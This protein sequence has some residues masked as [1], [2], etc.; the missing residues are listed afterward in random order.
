M[1]NFYTKFFASK[2]LTICLLL[3]PMM[4]NAINYGGP[5]D[6]DSLA[7]WGHCKAVVEI[8]T[9]CVT[10]DI[11]IAAFV[12]WTFTGVHQPV[13]GT[14][15]TGQVA[16]KITVVPPGTWSWD[17]NGTT[18]EEYHWGNEGS[19][20]VAFFAGPIELTPPP[21]ICPN[22]GPLEITT[23]I[24]GYSNF[25]SIVWSP[26]NPAGDTEPYPITQP[27]TYGLTV[28]DAL[29]CTSS[30]QVTI[31][32][33]PVFTPTIIGP[34]RL[35]PEGDTGT[36]SIVNP[37]LYNFFEWGTGETTTPITIMDPGIYQVTATD[38]YGCTGVGSINVQSGN[39][40]P[41]SIAVSSSLLCPG[42]LDTLRVVGGFANYSWSNN[43]MGITNI[44]NQAGTYTVTVTNFYGCTGTAS[45]TVTPLFPPVI[46]VAG[47]PL[48]L[49]DTAIL[50]TTGGSF[51]QY[52]WS[53]GQT[54][55]SIST[56][57]PGTYSVTVS[58]AG[59]CATS[60]S[61]VLD[62]APAPTTI[63][64]SAAN[65][66]CTVLQTTLNG[67]NSSTGPTFPFTWKT[68]DG[69]FVSGDSTLNPVI[70]APGTYILSIVNTA[71]G[72]I[73][74]DTIVVMQN[75]TPPPADAGPSTMLNCAILNAVIG[76][77]PAPNDPSLLPS[78]SSMDGN[79]SSGQDTWAPGIDQP[80]TYIVLVTNA[81]NGCTSSASVVVGQDIAA[82]TA[83]IA[84][85]N[86]ITCMQGTVPLDGSGSSSGSNINY[87]WTTVNGL[88]AGPVDAAI[89]GASSIG[90]YDLLVTNTLNGC[91]TSASITVSA[92]VNIPTVGALPPGTLNC[93][94]LSTVI[95]ASGSS[96][97]PTF[98]YNWST[99]NGN[100]VS[101]GNTLMPSVNAPGAYT[102]NLLNTANNCAATLS[103]IVNQDITPPIA[104]A[105]LDAVL[106]CTAPTTIL[107]GSASSVGSNFTYNW[108]TA[109][110]NIVSGINTVFP[111]VDMDGT[112]TLQV[113]D[114]LNGCTAFASVVIMNDAN[115]PAALIAAPTTLTC[116]TLQTV[117]DATASTQT[118]N[119]SYAWSGNILSGQGTL[120]PIVD[121]P[122][123]YTLSI[124]NNTNGCTD[125]E[126][127]TV[128]QDILSP[129][130]QAGQDG[131]INCFNPSGTIGSLSNPSG[132]G[133]LLQWSTIGGNFISATNGP[134][135]LI[136][137]AGDYQLLITHTQNGCTSTDNVSVTADFN[138]PA[139]NAG[140]AAE[141]TCVQTSLSL[142]GSGGA[143]A[144]FNYLWTAA[145]G[146]NITSG[147]NSLSPVVDAPGTY[148]LLIT[149][150]INGCS[151]VSQ[152]SITENANG[153]MAS[154]G[155]PQTLTCIL[156]NTNLSAAG[157]STGAGFSYAW[158]AG[159]GGNI[160]A[161]ANTFTPS[162][163]APGTYTVTVTNTGNF[164][165]QTSSVT[166]LLN[167]QTPVVNAG[168][169]NT[170]TCVI[171]SLDLQA[172]I[173]SSSSQNIGYQWA[174]PTGQIISGG[175]TA[176]PIIGAPGNYLVTVTDVLNGC[177]GTDQLQI[178][179]DVTLPTAVIANPLMLTC[180]VEQVTLNAAASSQG[181]NFDYDWTTPAGNFVS[182]QNPQ[183]PIV[184]EQGLYNL[185]ITNTIN[186]CTQSASVTVPEDL[187]LPDAEAGE[188]V[189]LD[190]DTQTNSL[191]GT[192]SS[193]GPE[194]NY[195]WSTMNGQIISGINTLTPG[196]GAPGN[197]V[198][199]VLNMQNGCV[200]VDNVTVTQDVQA[201]LLA[202]A[203]PQTLTCTITSAILK[204]S[205]TALGNAPNIVW[206][207]SNGN[208][209]AGGTSLAPT[210]D[211]PG[212]YTLTVLNP[213]N[214]CS[215]TLPVIVTENIQTPPLQVQPAPLLT[216]SVLQFPLES[217]VPAQASMIW[218]TSNGNIVS[219]ANTSN[220]TVDEPG[221]YQLI[222][223]SPINGCTNSAQ[224][225]VQQELNI[226]TGL[227]FNLLP[228]LCNGTPGTLTV[229]QVN[230]G[231]GPFA[232]SVDGGQTF[233]ASEQFGQLTPG[234]Y[235]LV[236]QDAN[237][238]E[239]TESIDVPSPPI[240]LVTSPPVFEIALGENQE[241]LAIVPPPFPLG[242]VD[243]VI[244][245]PMNGLTFEGNTTLQLLHPMAQPFSTTQY[246]VTIVTK[247]GCKSS[248]RTIVK[249]D[250][251]A[252][253]YVP[254]VFRPD[255][256]DGN[257]G[258]FL[259][260]A[261]DE[262]IALIKKLQIFDRWGSLIFVNQDFR[263]ND[264]SA[265]WSGDY[266]GDPVNPGVFV[267][268]AEVELVDGRLLLVKGDVTVV[269]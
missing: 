132:S 78:W 50:T 251:E 266:R 267:W 33:V 207:T 172:Q 159:S 174:T 229:D 151:A 11:T 28:T 148:N 161:G 65:L 263:P 102:L 269:R 202:I 140:P 146:G 212:N 261:R 201:P 171:T 12:Y 74:R 264:T 218:T 95:D 163:D 265:G 41:F 235:E 76:P 84:P 223:T 255:D 139:A 144:N 23:N 100:I 125:V 179:A 48:C 124:T 104:D 129:N 208:I 24:N 18:C 30:D 213:A 38:G 31:I 247:E 15:S 158:S 26:P 225:A 194:F 221:L 75:I 209:V 113:T 249:V 17:P 29:G 164:C 262:S 133:Y 51:P 101:G 123:I 119:L 19:F 210:I 137:Q 138:I 43:V 211:A 54:T 73:T 9:N 49:G 230:G 244:W 72:C 204:G 233:F 189:G 105:G 141:L 162:I 183:Q 250:R 228:P 178:S 130:V 155:L 86:L 59:I 128:G 150:T 253:I 239:I 188:V 85:T 16:H 157:S 14:W 149:N 145:S 89:S 83:Q 94:V 232:Y 167:V 257:N 175:N 180:T 71:T 143:G 216:C 134:T 118:G 152:V 35:C 36:L 160:T 142:Q 37:M 96:S 112:Y 91:A 227:H 114:Q 177:T 1:A 107:D 192:S 46:Q 195:T 206:A 168:P 252:D 3:L 203:P 136:D 20:N 260:F 63:I 165:T 69:N 242:L 215:A 77:V 256:P 156:T 45:T 106:N 220:P 111:T 173:V 70:D 245:T 181:S 58:G 200:Q 231:I 108:A 259:V 154:A 79:I 258:T 153:P 217:T 5:T 13:V 199:T 234:N 81:I 120:Q 42:L 61:T 197:Y 34:V 97:G 10:Q 222:I 25:S 103:V 224:I 147:A 117:I 214:G 115:A 193:Q 268:W 90:T 238:C 241:I 57:M 205:G 44:V 190:C 22:D 135:A 198:L 248:A 176:S 52:N 53:S 185:L 191:D 170:L 6:P 68:P 243:T 236:I 92:D 121:Q 27:G 131:L 80:G 8:D 21:A 166:I 87:W 99:M 40:D 122:G 126:S 196:I 60:T 47:T 109:D 226:P 237:G 64:D 187:Q 116:T 7:R 62:F 32:E 219:G 82:P 98:Q 39:V 66:N 182:T 55:Q 88:L 186:G 246:T 4:A 184:D 93:M 169:D 110:G 254:N 240:P 56:S 67:S 127:V 2:L